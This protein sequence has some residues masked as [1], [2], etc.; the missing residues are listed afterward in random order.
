VAAESAEADGKTAVWLAVD[1]QICAVIAVSDT[2]KETSP[3]AIA[4]L[5]DLGLTPVL[6]TGDNHRAAYAVARQ[7]GIDEHA[8][9][10]PGDVDLLIFIRVK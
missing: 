4:E 8:Q 3:A 2:V 1:E 5:R 10:P 7:L 6:L 9:R